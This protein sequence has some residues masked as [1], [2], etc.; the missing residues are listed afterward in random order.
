LELR[1]ALKH[2]VGKPGGKSP[3]GDVGVY[4]RIILKLISEKRGVMMQIRVKC[5][6]IIDHDG[7][8]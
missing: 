5:L 4:G 3:L 1:N 6:V 8:L 7:L 2:F